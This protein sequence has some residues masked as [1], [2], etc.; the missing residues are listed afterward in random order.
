MGDT[1]SDGLQAG[2]R[3][4]AGAFGAGSVTFRAIMPPDGPPGADG[5]SPEL[6]AALA[7][8]LGVLGERHSRLA[9]VIA[10]HGR[11]LRAA[12]QDYQA[13]EEA[14][15]DMIDRILDPGAPG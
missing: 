14:I 10:G 2:L 7:Q 1:V 12:G 5:G 13:A 3:R 11:R 9:A 8:V 4:A 15:G 6:D